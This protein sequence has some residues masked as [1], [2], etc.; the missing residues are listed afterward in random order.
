MGKILSVEVKKSQV[1]VVEMEQSKQRNKIISCFRFFIPQDL[2]E[3]GFVKEPEKLGTLLR[4]E[5]D[6]RSLHKIKKVHFSIYSSRIAGKEIHLPY[7]KKKR[8][9]DMIEMNASEYFPVDISQYVLTYD[10]IDIIEKK[11]EENELVEEK[12]KQPA[13]KEY[14]LMVYAAPKVLTTCYQ[15]TAQWA[16]LHLTGMDYSNNSIYQ[17]IKKEYS[18]GVHMVVKIEE[19]E[20]V[21]TIIRDGK[22]ALQR[23]LSYGIDGAIEAILAYPVYHTNGDYERAWEILFDKKCLYPTLDME[24]M[25]QYKERDGEGLWEAKADITESFRHLIGNVSRIM[26]YYISRNVGAEFRSVSYAGMGSEIKG[27]SELFTE[28]IGQEVVPIQALRGIRY[29]SYLSE[30]QDSLGVF[31]SGIGGI[32]SSVNIMEV[33]TNKKEKSQDSLSGA[34][35]ILGVGV[36]SALMISGY[37]VGKYYLETKEKERLNSEISKR[38]HVEQVYQ[39][40]VSQKDIYDQLEAML[41]YTKTPNENLIQFIEEMEE[42][43]P[44]SILLESFSSTGSDVNFTARATSKAIVAKVI[45]QM[46]TFESL[47]YVST[48]GV[49]EDDN[50]EYTFSVTAIYKEPAQAISEEE[51]E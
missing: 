11:Q 22:L 36:V 33:V 13:N 41:D 19:E 32:Q 14:Q 7:V 39:E 42:K 34:W 1:R 30:E 45:M 24:S 25:G 35:L 31:I 43:M 10:I 37:S 16:G 27:L 49:T 3:D 2:V 40:Y 17:A 46:R 12:E 23:S 21:I 9:L 5:L 28:E 51:Q 44:S 47:S 6:K 26:D 8:I 29:D 4:E 48:S 18:E 50:G 20:S 15:E 38:E